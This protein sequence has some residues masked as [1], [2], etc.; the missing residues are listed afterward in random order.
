M[1]KK[2]IL[3]VESGPAGPDVAAEYNRW[4][5]EVHIPEMLAIEGIVSAR[6][7]APVDGD[8][9]IA[10]YEIEGDPKAAM[11]RLRDAAS[12][13][14]MHLSDTARTDPPARMLLMELVVERDAAASG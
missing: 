9:Y 3:H 7:Y 14:T 4:Y 12:D 10:H 5:D 13:G 11:K 8:T 2:T 6:R 1:P